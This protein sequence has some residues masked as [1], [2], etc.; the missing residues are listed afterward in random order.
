LAVAGMLWGTGFVFGKWALD[1]LSVGH[2]ILYRFA[3]A[4]LALAPVA[5][6]RPASTRAR[7]DRRDVPIFLVAALLGV[8]LQ[9]LV[10][11][12]GLRR[13]TVS[14]ASL[15]VGILP[16][17]LGAGAAILG[18]H[19]SSTRWAALGASVLGAALIALGAVAER[20][21]GGATVLGDGLVILSLIVAVAWMLLSQRLMTG[22][23]PY[24]PV[25]TSAY[26]IIAGTVML[27][28]WVVAREGPPPLALSARTWISV[29]AQG[30]LATALTTLLW[31]WGLA[32]VPASQAGVFVNL[33]PVVGAVL[34]LLLFGDRL[35]P[36]A[37]VGGLLVL[38]AAVVV[39][40]TTSGQS[41][42]AVDASGVP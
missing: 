26:I 18:E 20:S 24:S 14:H 9:F 1:E 6:Q 5:W 30:L 41:A 40:R 21:A 34:G 12:E 31:N 23:R 22:R 33:E 29:A 16:A 19:V 10:Q 35:G 25:V 37:I 42:P 32:R 27:A 15:M 4:S 7:I 17:L 39:T 28:I 36:I 2:M 8:P 13:T 11:F 38:G 3:F